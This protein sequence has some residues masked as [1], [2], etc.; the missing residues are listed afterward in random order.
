VCATAH[1]TLT[2]SLEAGHVVGALP[3]IGVIVNPRSGYNLRNPRAAR[4][5][6]RTLGSRGVVREAGSL[7]ELYKVAEDFRKLDIDV[8]GISG[9][10]GTNGVT[11]TGFLDVYAG[12]ALPQIAFLRGGT[13]NVVADSVGVRRGPPE[14]LLGQ[15]LHVY[16]ARR[17]LPLL[18]V[19][20]HVM[21]IRTASDAEP[22][23]PLSTKY[24][25][26]FGT[27][28]VAG[29]LA[30]YYR[31]GKP[32]P[33]VAA[34]TLL[35]AMGSTLVR[36]PMIRRMAEPFHGSAHLADGAVWPERDYLAIAGGTIDQIGLNFKPFCRSGERPGAFH[37]L[38]IHTSPLRFLRQ[39][40][41]IFRGE[42]MQPGHAHD[43]LVSGVTLRAS[44]YPLKYMVDGDLYETRSPLEV[45]IGPT[46][47]IV[48]VDDEALASR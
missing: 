4:K 8:L 38:G 9:G 41:R 14:G 11:I 47:R 25:F 15:L 16:L 36:G 44:Q 13:A 35:R 40:G 43:A 12:S 21:R 42:P 19:E 3:G 2:G 39:M 45:S 7:D 20:Q 46:V 28:V 5:L 33:L 32:T 31:G 23:G 30:E 1:V 18:D 17:S 29:F 26:L 34:Q 48:V 10:D 6:A 37:L 27:G 22:Q 24:G